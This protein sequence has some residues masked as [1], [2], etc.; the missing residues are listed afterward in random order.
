MNTHICTIHEISSRFGYHTAR[1]KTPRPFSFEPGQYIL[2]SREADYQ[3][4]IPTVQFIESIIGEDLFIASQAPVDWIPGQRILFRGPLGHGF[5]LPTLFRRMLLIG[6]DAQPARLMSLIHKG[7]EKKVDIVLAGDF[8]ANPVI[9]ESIPSQVELAGMDQLPELLLW[10]DFVGMDLPIHHLDRLPG[11]ISN[12]KLVGAQALIH[13]DMPCG[14]I[15]E[16]GI[17]AVKTKRGYK[18]ACLDGPVFDLADL[19]L[20]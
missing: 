13:T 10:S 19:N 2:A 6:L 5:R 9:S 17:C 14:G 4:T 7:L 20:N 3:Q 8:I 18:M 15:A 1:L 11:M 12:V 16:C